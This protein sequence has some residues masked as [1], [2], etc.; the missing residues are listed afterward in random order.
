MINTFSLYAEPSNCTDFRSTPFMPFLP[1]LPRRLRQ[2]RRMQ[3]KHMPSI[4]IEMPIKIA[5]TP[6]GC[7]CSFSLTNSTFLSKNV[8]FVTFGSLDAPTAAAASSADGSTGM[9]PNYELRKASKSQSFVDFS[10][11]RRWIGLYLAVRTS[12]GVC[13]QKYVFAVSPWWKHFPRLQRPL[14]QLVVSIYVDWTPLLSLKIE[15]DK[16]HFSDERM[17]CVREFE[18]RGRQL[19]CV[20]VQ[21]S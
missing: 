4:T 8:C 11:I 1:S 15:K 13:D 21:C 10:R 9:P 5:I 2:H 3:K 17:C 20:L 14:P 7:T 19:V 18:A 16:I 6:H 12:N